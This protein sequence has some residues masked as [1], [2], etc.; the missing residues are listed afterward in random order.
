[1][2]IALCSKG[3]PRQELSDARLDRTYDEHLLAIYAG[4]LRSAEKAEFACRFASSNRTF[5]IAPAAVRLHIR[6]RRTGT[7]VC[8]VAKHGR[9][10]RLVLRHGSDNGL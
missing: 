4:I 5:G 10:C 3:Y 1:M 8:A 2:R 7:P 9:A 6:R